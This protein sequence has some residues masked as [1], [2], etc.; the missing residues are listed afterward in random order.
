MKTLSRLIPACAIVALCLPTLSARAQGP[1]YDAS[2]YAG[3]KS[4]KM[5]HKKEET[6]AQFAKWEA[7]PHSKTWEMLG[8]DESKEIAAKLGID[9][10]QTSGKCLKCH[11]TAY[12]FTEEVQTTKIKVE[13][14]VSCESCHGPGKNYKKKEIMKDHDQSV[15]NGMVYPAKEKSCTHCHNEGSATWDPKR[16]TLADGTTTG[17]DV[18]QAWEKIAHPRPTE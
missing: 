16:Y 9:D 5:C 11:A 6:G 8:S 4:C 2:L 18:D 14:G 17:F 15:A 7:G 12:N 10:P 3:T 13:E 1:D